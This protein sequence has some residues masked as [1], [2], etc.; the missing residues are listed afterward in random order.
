MDN[1]LRHHVG[2]DDSDRTITRRCVFGHATP[3]SPTHL[4]SEDLGE[5]RLSLRVAGEPDVHLHRL[6]CN[7]QA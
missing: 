6:R 7:P 1:I 3:L 2:S 4:I 5:R